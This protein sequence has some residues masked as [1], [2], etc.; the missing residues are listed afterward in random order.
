MA[1][2]TLDWRGARVKPRMRAAAWAGIR[3]A[4][5]YFQREL[6]RVI[7]ISNRNGENRS[8]PGEPPRRETGNLQKNVLVEL[9]ERK[10]VARVGVGGNAKYGAWLEFGTRRILPRPWIRP[11]I[12]RLRATLAQVARKTAERFLGASEDEGGKG[13]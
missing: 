1:R 10:H 12:E 6:K 11:T 8:A 2:A 3:A 9:D 13:A 7:G 4:A 5:L